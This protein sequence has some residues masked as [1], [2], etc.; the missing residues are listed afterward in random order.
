MNAP[1]AVCGATRRRSRAGRQGRHPWPYMDLGNLVISPGAQELLAKADA[2]PL[3]YAARHARC[4]WRDLSE[5]DRRLNW[6]ALRTGQPVHS[7]CR[8]PCG[9][10]LWLVTTGRK[11]QRTTWMHLPGEVVR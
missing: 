2:T 6:D 8:L 7:M 11:D 10:V 3:G 5:E 4:D 1:A 9:E